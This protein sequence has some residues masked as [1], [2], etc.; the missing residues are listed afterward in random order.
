MHGD[1]DGTTPSPGRGTPPG[2]GTPPGRD[3]PSGAP[4]D[5]RSAPT[6][7]ASM[8]GPAG[9]T[10]AWGQTRAPGDSATTWGNASATRWES[11]LPPARPGGPVGAPG[12]RPLP[13]FLRPPAVWFTSVAAVGSVVL[14][15]LLVLALLPPPATHTSVAVVV[16]TPGTA[17]PLPRPAATATSAPLPAF[18]L[19]AFHDWRA[20]Y[21]AA[22]GHVHVTT[23]DGQTDLA[24]PALDLATAFSTNSTDTIPT[25]DAFTSLAVAPNGQYL[26]YIDQPPETGTGFTPPG[27]DLVVTPL[28]AGAA[29][30]WAAQRIPAQVTTI[31]GWSPDSATIAFSTNSPPDSGSDSHTGTIYTASAPTWRPQ[32]LPGAES[33]SSPLATAQILGWRDNTHLVLVASANNGPVGTP[34]PGGTGSVGGSALAAPLSPEQEALVTV[35]VATGAAYTIATIPPGT[36]VALSPDGTQVVAQNTGNTCAQACSSQTLTMEVIDTRTGA[37]QSLPASEKA[38]P[39][40]IAIN[41]NPQGASFAATIDQGST[42]TAPPRWR[43]VLVDTANDSAWTARTGDFAVGWSPDGSALLIGDA[44]HIGGDG[45]DDGTQVWGM[46]PGSGGAPVALPKLMVAFIGWVR[47]A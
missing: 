42:G 43:V 26:A 41:W 14:V 40:A 36:L 34:L 4:W 16:R 37:V 23:L 39:G 22:D 1:R 18:A 25:L 28:A 31:G 7:G 33:F 17:T 11:P 45:T 44:S 35:D 38:A 46:A 29:P 2:Y 12:G 13:A 30:G 9:T 8:S 6:R 21:L 32:P 24:G 10:P 3:T 15:V 5:A 19:P 20:A 27:G 47:T